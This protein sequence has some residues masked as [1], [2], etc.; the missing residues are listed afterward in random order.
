MPAISIDTFFACSLM[1]TVVVAAMAVTAKMVQPYLSGIEDLNQKDYLREISDHIL[2]NPGLPQNWGSNKTSIIESFGLAKNGSLDPYELDIDK[3]CRLNP[4]NAYHISYLSLIKALKVKKVAIRISIQQILNIFITPIK[5]QSN[6][7][8]TNYTFQIRVKRNGFPVSA[9]LH[10][11]IIA[12]NF[13]DDVSA[14]T[15][16]NGEATISFTIPNSSNGTALLI[17]FARNSQDSRITSYAVYA[18]SH[19]SENPLPNNSFIN[20]SPLNYTLYTNKLFA[21]E[22]ILEA[23]ALTYSYNETITP[24]SNITY[25]IPKFLDKSPI[26]LVV[27]GTN[28]STFFAEWV[29]YPQIPLEMGANVQSSENTSFTYIISIN[30]ALYE[31]RIQCEGA[32]E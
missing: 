5:N 7:N 31:V 6:G 10:C 23:Y 29:A 12:K 16:S 18:F 27:T 26:V 24:I 32:G 13:F 8:L 11:Y 19:L 1:I 17:T 21:N 30:Q 28:S 2:L 22:T 4:E 15:S 25:T 14:E 9:S 20:L 3:V